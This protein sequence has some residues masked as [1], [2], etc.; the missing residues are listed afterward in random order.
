[1]SITRQVIKIEQNKLDAEVQRASK[2]PEFQ[3]NIEA[4]KK[5]IAQG[6]SLD[7]CRQRLPRMSDRKWKLHTHALGSFSFTPGK[8]YA[9]FYVK[10]KIR[11]QM[12]IDVYNTAKRDGDTRA[13]TT[14][15][16]TMVKLDE[17]MLIW[18]QNLGVLQPEEKLIDGGSGID[19]A[20]LANEYARLEQEIRD[21]LRDEERAR[22]KIPLT[23]LS[24]PQPERE[25][26]TVEPL[27]VDV[28]PIR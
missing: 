9:E 26:D 20:A 24:E 21:R 23:L 10:S 19:P 3:R 18:A 4:I 15:I 2:R 6:C 22:V 16:M 8:L 12:L 13:Q 1:M 27:T 11:M 5:N 14:A 17:S 28:K 25:P 7:E